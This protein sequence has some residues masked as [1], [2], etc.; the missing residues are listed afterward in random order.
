M[1]FL[2]VGLPSLAAIPIHTFGAQDGMDSL[3]QSVHLT[4][5]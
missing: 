3:L 2:E 5:A 4:L 1:Q